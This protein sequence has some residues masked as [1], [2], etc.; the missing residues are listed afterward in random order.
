M[1]ARTNEAINLETPRDVR[2]S[3]Y[4]RLKAAINGT[5]KPSQ[6]WEHFSTAQMRDMNCDRSDVHPCVCRDRDWDLSGEEHCDD[7]LI[8][9]EVRM[10]EHIKT[11]VNSQFL[12]KS[13][14]ITSWLGGY[15][16]QGHLLKRTS[17]VYN[18]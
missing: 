12:V 10:I 1:H 11:L 15:E 13:A 6:Q 17:A 16:R 2:S 8:V 4:W 14:N 3:R 7:F 9:G 5:P 18:C